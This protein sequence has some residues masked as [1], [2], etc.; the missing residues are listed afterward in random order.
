METKKIIH[1]SN[2]GAW[3]VLQNGDSKKLSFVDWIIC[4]VIERIPILLLSFKFYFISMEKR[5]VLSKNVYRPNLQI[6]PLHF[7]KSIA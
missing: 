6:L 7:W 4:E 5:L 2:S 1:K 3:R